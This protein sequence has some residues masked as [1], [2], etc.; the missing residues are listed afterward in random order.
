MVMSRAIPQGTVRRGC[1]IVSAGRR[2]RWEDPSPE[3]QGSGLGA[4]GSGLGAWGSGLGARGSRLGTR[5]PERNL[6]PGTWNLERAE[7]SYTGWSARRFSWPDADAGIRP[8]RLQ[9]SPGFVTYWA[10][11]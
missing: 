8:V 7:R 4:R 1:W 2:D 9:R 6:E 3:T 5:N 10:S 11:T